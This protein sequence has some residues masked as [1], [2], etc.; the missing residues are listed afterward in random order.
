[1]NGFPLSVDS[2]VASSSLCSSRAS[3]NLLINRA[4]C[5]LLTLDQVLDA[6]L[7]AYT[8]SST[9]YFPADATS[10]MTYSVA[11]AIV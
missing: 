8:A 3:A 5:A 10:V 4:R 2:I 6:C 9:S 7:A 11:G 1:M